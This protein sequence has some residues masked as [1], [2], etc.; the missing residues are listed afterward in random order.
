MTYA[1]E[2]ASLNNQRT[3]RN[4]TMRMEASNKKSLSRVLPSDTPVGWCS[5]DGGS[6]PTLLDICGVHCPC[7]LA[8]SSIVR[9]FGLF[10]LMYFVFLRTE[11]FFF[12]FCVLHFWLVSMFIYRWYNFLFLLIKLMNSTRLTSTAEMYHRKRDN[13]SYFVIVVPQLRCHVC[14]LPASCIPLSGGT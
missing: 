11:D 7:V 6:W 9:D 1:V 4:K 2:K 10:S 13:V 12:A 14:L 8:D 5:Q 3:N